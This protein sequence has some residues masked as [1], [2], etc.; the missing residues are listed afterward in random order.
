MTRD[1]YLRRVDY[2]LRDLPWGTRRDLLAEIRGHL[3]ELPADTDLEARLGTPE[4]YAADLRSAAG[5]E[6]R[7]GP[8]AFVRARRPRNLILLAVL[9]T[10][11]GLAIGTAAWIDSYQPIAFAGSTLLPATAQGDT[12]SENFSVVFHKGK[13]F[14]FGI[15]VQNTGRFTVRILGVPEAPPFFPVSARLL[16]SGPDPSGGTAGPFERFHPFDMKPGEVRVLF[17]RGDFACTTGWTAGGG[18][19]LVDFPVRFSFLWRTATA[20]IPL[21]S[22][23]AIQFHSGCPSKR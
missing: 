9:L 3:D 22:Q 6:R 19:T 7:R 16:M 4:K 23:L 17:F 14:R 2:R 1:E 20:E 5:L 18:L 11:I 12:A 21:R 13:P 8:V 15:T 10:L